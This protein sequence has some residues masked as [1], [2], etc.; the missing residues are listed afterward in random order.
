MVSMKQ[1]NYQCAKHNN[2]PRTAVVEGGNRP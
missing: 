1:T 2:P